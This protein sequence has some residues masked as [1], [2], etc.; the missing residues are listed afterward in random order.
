M[1]NDL[2]QQL[3]TQLRQRHIVTGRRF[4]ERQRQLRTLVVVARGEQLEAPFYRPGQGMCAACRSPHED[5]HRERSGMSDLVERVPDRIR[6]FAQRVV[7][8]PLGQRRS[9]PQPANP[10]GVR[11]PRVEIVLKALFAQ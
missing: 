11:H 3:R 6:V 4:A 8:A 2:E 10:T 1:N 5:E 9:N 7:H